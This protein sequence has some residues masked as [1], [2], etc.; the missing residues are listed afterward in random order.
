MKTAVSRFAD[1][2]LTLGPKMN[3]NNLNLYNVTNY[4]N[5]SI[6]KGGISSDTVADNET[7]NMLKK[8]N[9]KV[10]RFASGLGGGAISE[11]ELILAGDAGVPEYVVR[12]DQLLNSHPLNAVDFGE[13][14]QVL[15]YLRED[16]QNI[17]FII[18]NEVIGQANDKYKRDRDRISIG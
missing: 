11:P 8:Q 14:I 3:R 5:D 13:I 17:H 1:M 10:R 2:V 15:N 4:F 18:D 16:V 6:G 9:F 12:E 7:M